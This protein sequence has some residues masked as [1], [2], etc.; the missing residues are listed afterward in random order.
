MQA[1]VEFVARHY[2]GFLCDVGIGSGAFIELRG[3]TCGYDVC[4][5]A[6]EWLKARHL[7]VDPYHVSFTA[8]SLWD[9]LEHIPEFWRLLRHVEQ[10]LFV[11]LP[12]FANAAHV[13]RSKHFRPDEHCWHFSRDGLVTVMQC[14]GFEL[15]EETD[16]ETRIG[17]EDIGAFAFRRN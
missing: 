17:R 16:M 13:L 8:M 4:P 15:M 7:W 3:Q 6:I 14:L 1:R 2:H 10:W 12:I 11:S 5:A 9:V